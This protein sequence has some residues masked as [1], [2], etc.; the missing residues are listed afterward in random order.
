V[1]NTKYKSVSYFEI[2]EINEV[3]STA[4]HT[5]FEGT[6][7]FVCWLNLPLINQTLDPIN[8]IPYEVLG[9]VPR[10]L[11]NVS[12]FVF[13]QVIGVDIKHNE[14]IFS[15]Y[16]YEESETQYLMFPFDFFA[17]DFKLRFRVPIVCINNVTLNPA[18]C[19]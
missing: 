7:R 3:D 11:S 10:K 16:S 6:V 14:D 4:H 13:C 8:N 12:P 5:I 17:V 15:K 19:L 18:S 9:V 2:Q 1:P